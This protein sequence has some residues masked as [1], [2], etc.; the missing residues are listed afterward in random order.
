M[1]QPVAGHYRKLVITG[2]C[3]PNS[4]GIVV[5][6]GLRFWLAIIAAVMALVLPLAGCGRSATP[7]GLRPV[8]LMLDWTPNTNHNG[9][10]L[11]KARGWYQQAGIDLTIIQPGET[12]SLAPLAAGK[13]DVAVSVAEEVLPARAEGLPVVSIAAIIQHNTSSLLALSSSGIRRPKDLEGHTYG[14]FGGALEHA[15]VDSLVRCD[16]GDPAKV[17]YVPAGNTDYR[18][19]LARK[20]YDVVWIFDGWDGLRL[21][22]LGS[23]GVTTMPFA[24]YSRCVP[25]WYTPV[26]VA[27]EVKLARDPSLVAAFMKATSRG[28][29]EAMRDPDAASTALL[30]AVPELDAKLVGVSSKY[31]ATRY[32]ASPA[33]WGQQDPAVWSRFAAFLTTTKVITGDAKVAGAFTNSFLSSTPPAP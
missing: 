13:A 32:A 19:G 18:L 20:T 12:G 14:G 5:T 8:T 21:G 24:S 33:A 23:L 26:L 4:K 15:L 22:Q 28:Y 25:D 3:R 16:G 17:R 29:A 30:T 27:N 2:A 11:A 31:L 10:Y 6:R 1:G 7:V 9:I